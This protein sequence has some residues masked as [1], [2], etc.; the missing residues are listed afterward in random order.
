MRD[1]LVGEQAMFEGEQPLF[2]FV[3][4]D[5]LLAEAVAKSRDKAAVADVALMPGTGEGKPPPLMGI[6]REHGFSP[7]ILLTVA[8]F[9][10]DTIINGMGI[11]GP[12][13][14]RAF[15][16]SDAGLG[17]V[18]FVGA[19][20][21]IGWGMPVAV[22]ADRGSRKNVAAITLL[23]FSVTIPIM[24]FMHDV[25]PY[26][27]LFLLAAIGLGSSDTVHNAY[28]SDAYPTH[29]RAR[30]FAW[31]NMNDPVSQTVGILLV[32]YIAAA[33]HNWRW[34]FALALIGI[35]VALL[36]FRIREPAKGANESSHI[37]R[38]AGMDIESEQEHAPKVLL[39]SAVT[40]LLRI[41]SLYYQL[42]SVAILGFAGT[43]IPLFGSLYFER[44]WHLGVAHRADVFAIIGLSQFLGLPVAF[45]VGDRLFRRAPEKPLV[46]AGFAITIFGGGYAVSLYMPH[47]WMVVAVQFVAQASSAVLSI[48]IFQT[49]AA[50]A[51]PEM[52]AICF[53]LFGVYAL[54]FGG[55]AGSILLGAVSDATNVT[56]A[57]TLIGPVCAVGG[58]MLVVGSR[59]VRSDITLV[60]EDVIERYAEGKRRKSG[61]EI[62]ALQIH[63][64]D[65]YYGTQQVLFDINVEIPE[66]DIVALLGTNGAGKS[67][68][69]RAV[70]GLDHPHR[71]VIRVF[72]TNCTYLESE[73]IID[74]GAALLVGGKMTFPG[75]TVRDNLR[76]GE[77]T[78]RRESAR[79]KTAMEEAVA[80]F[81]ELEDR[82][83]QPAGTL[84]G[85]EQQ[86]L[87]LARV[88]MTKPR[89][90]MIDELAFGLAPMTVERLM[91]IVRRVNA[92][93]A[94]VILVE[95]SVNRAMTLAQRAIFLERGEIRFDGSITELLERDDLLRP[96]FLA[97]VGS[98][99]G[100]GNGAGA[101]PAH[102]A[103]PV[104]NGAGLTPGSPAGGATPGNGAGATP[105]PTADPG[106]PPVHP[107]G[108]GLWIVGGT[109]GP[110]GGG[111][112]GDTP[113]GGPPGGAAGPPS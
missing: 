98:V 65:F 26:A 95:Q 82:L 63:N 9:V 29:G 96:V 22:F 13:I 38:A 41:R 107:G 14:K 67:T 59:F 77:H 100:T 4:P 111:G 64:M 40:R 2:N 46:L 92:Q 35:P 81:P 54:V 66:G 93:G 27:F 90:L 5:E 105:G 19:V 104:G 18:T 56:T 103:T 28:L 106:T 34:A 7:L 89:L 44:V 58:L 62:P 112:D 110:A 86:M 8:A 23:V 53:G 16:L 51:P 73:Q 32:G 48:C 72:G 68:L 88:M 57:L 80:M 69:L 76:I 55:F 99:L 25:W 37:L 17:A 45:L 36:T 97:S 101:G 83:D 74:L 31:H 78:F 10:T 85:G 3:V 79:A 109:P 108:D 102:T 71:G 24:A 43:G 15:H 33:T 39:G 84:S 42:V 113:P 60:I 12:E 50:T 87:A 61:G 70:S 94:T 11:L 49:L 47:L 52:R 20:A 30:I 6:L 75:M 91:D 1:P 21:Q